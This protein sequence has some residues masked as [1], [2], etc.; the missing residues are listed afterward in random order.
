[1]KSHNLTQ[2]TPAWHAHRAKHFNASD[3][4]AMLGVSPYKTR[5]QLLH[6]A[7]T[8]FMPEIDASTQRRFDEGHRFEAL[9]RPRAEE[10]IGED[11]YPV[12]GSKGRLSAS[13]DGLTL[14]EEVIWEHKTLNQEISACKNAYDLP[15][16]Y[17]VQMEQQ[18]YVSGANRCLFMATKWDGN[19]Q[20]TDKFSVW[21]EP[22]LTLRARIMAGWEQFEI[23]LTAYKPAVEMPATVVADIEDLPALTVEL[24]GQVTKSNLISFKATV[25]ARIKAIDEN[26]Q[27][28]EDFYRAEK[29][30]KF[31]DDGEK[32]LELVKS[33]ALSQTVSIDELLRTMDQLKAEMRAK[34]LTL[35]KL[36][37]MRKESIRIDILSEAKRAFA[38]HSEGLNKRLGKRYM[39]TITTDFAGVM[40]GKKTVSSLN[41]AVATELA[42]AK[43]EANAVAD[44]IQMNLLNLRALGE[45]FMFL[46]A[47]AAQ[48]V[49][50]SND[51][52]ILLIER[53]I[54]DHKAEECERRRIE[55]KLKAASKQRLQEAEE[56]ERQ[57]AIAVKAESPAT[58]PAEVVVTV[59]NPVPVDLPVP[60]FAHEI[61]ATNAPVEHLATILYTQIINMLNVM[62]EA[63]LGRA[64]EAVLSIYN[65]MDA[66]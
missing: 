43:I 18:L 50:K 62:S 23:D 56:K 46:F 22:N 13:F 28:D 20:L 37:K 55:E 59:N 27:T 45:G 49:L 17:R 24:V 15:E 60:V 3:A 8:G 26:L 61:A 58:V 5:S 31:L 7:S 9:A 11:L 1:M 53:R 29:L 12:T 64:L 10:L 57:R 51:D 66:A 14:S 2:N 33:Q 52:F 6:E 48:L 4:P 36:V 34:R 16:M 40:K 39:P 25:M 42:R 44:A 19:D 54:A 21:Y 63:Q 35:D 41:D 32:R 65:R 30:V 38:E 47:D